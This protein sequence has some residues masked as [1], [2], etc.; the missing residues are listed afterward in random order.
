[1][2]NENL[3]L[4]LTKSSFRRKRTMK[5]LKNILRDIEINVAKSNGFGIQLIKPVKLRR[6]LLLKEINI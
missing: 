6:S 4:L 5:S 3:K 1:M 2:F